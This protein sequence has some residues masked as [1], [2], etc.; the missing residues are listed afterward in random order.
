MSE[1]LKPLPCPFC[2]HEEPVRMINLGECCVIC[3]EC[4]SKGPTASYVYED[5]ERDVRAWNGKRGE[6]RC[7]AYY[8][9]ML[10]CIDVPAFETEEQAEEYFKTSVQDGIEFRTFARIK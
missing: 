10:H 6:T 4:G 3:P 8:D 5:L 9:G 7:F 1:G 2:G